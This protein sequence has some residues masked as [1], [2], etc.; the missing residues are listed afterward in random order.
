M[1]RFPVPISLTTTSI[2]V[3]H[4]TE[5]DT[6]MEGSHMNTVQWL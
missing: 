4:R 6:T 1:T 5:P 2:R 3:A